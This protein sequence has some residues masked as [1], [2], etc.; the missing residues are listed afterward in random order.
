MTRTLLVSTLFLIACGGDD[1]PGLATPDHCNPLGGASCIT[2]WPS[3]AYEVDDASSRTGRRLDVPAGAL[4]TNIDGIALEPAHYNERDGFSSAAPLTTAFSTG[5]DPSNLVHY[6]NYAASV[7]D[8]SPTVLIDMSTGE[9]VHHFAE[10]DASAASR[11]ANQAL[12][13]RPAAQLAGGRRYAVAIK[14]TL[15]AKG[16]GELP[17]PEG[18]QAIVDG[19]KTSHPLLERIRPRYP[20]IFE[21]LAA[22][23]ISPSDLVVAWDFTTASRESVRSDLVSA[24]DA[25]L[26]LIGANGANLTYSVTSNAPSSD[27]RIAA[28][29]DG[30]FDAPLFLSNGGGT[31][32]SVTLLRTADGKPRPDGVYRVPFTAVIPQC[33]LTSPTPVPMMIYGHGLLG[34]SSQVHSSGTRHASAELCVVA[35]GTDMRG[36]AEVDV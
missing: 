10:L 13:I 9:L 25:A 2:P 12:F 7:T 22:H 4:P 27:A 33:A 26:P 34:D 14:R 35:V 19:T 6:S 29:I 20:A 8:A 18:F 16:G 3:S 21:A 32:A 36:M 11:P 5:V 30:A 24:R 15:K 23:G 31:S 17:I 1:A 28:R